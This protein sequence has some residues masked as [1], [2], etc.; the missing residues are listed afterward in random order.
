[1]DKAVDVILGKVITIT[2]NTDMDSTTVNDQ[3]FTLKQGTVLVQGKVA[4]TAST[5][6]FTFTPTVPLLPFTIYTGTV[7]TG[8]KDTFHS[9]IAEEYTWS[10]TTI[11]VV[12]LTA[13][14]AIGGTTLGAGA[15]AQG[16][17]VA[18]EATPN[19]GYV[20][21]NWTEEGNIV[22]T[23][24]AYSSA[25]AGNKTLVA[26]FAVLAA[27]QF[28]VVLS[29]NPIAGGANVGSGAYAAGTAV[30]VAATPNA[31][32]TFINWTEGGTVVS[33]SPSYQFNI[34]ASRSLR[35]NY[36]TVPA[37]Q[38]A[39]TLSSSPVSGGSTTGSGSY[40]AATSVT[41]NAAPNM[42]YTF[43]SWTE[44]GVIVS[45]SP[46]YTLVIN[47]N[48]TL[49]ANFTINTYTLILNAVNGTATASPAQATYNYGATVQ[50]TAKPNAGY[51]FS[52]WTGDAGGAVSPITVTMTANK[53]ITANFVP[54]AGAGPIDIDLGTAG[55]FATLT[56][57]GISTT[58]LTTVT[59]NIGVS[60]SAATSITGFGLIMDTDGTSSHTPIVIGK[61]YA[62]NYAAPTP[63]K[64][65]T[66]VS[67]MET[68]FSAGNALVTPAPVVGLYDGDLS[69]RTL[70]AGLYKWSTGVLITNQGL[71]LNGG[72]NDV[73]VFQIAQDLT[74]NNS[75]IITLTGGAQAKNIFWVV[76]GQAT[77]GSNSDV[78]GIILSKTLISLNT[79]A[80]VT[81]RL[82][83][84]TAV[85]LNAST[86]I[87]P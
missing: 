2:F 64:M 4:T 62:A 68:A 11:P 38:F 48:K 29:S 33:T 23:S 1:M 46:A 50:L 7:T 56:K 72:P 69:G 24:A 85:T 86:V 21:V 49:V 28:A 6:I 75:A 16:A 63:A 3:T 81:G 66:A 71:I 84:Q 40:N 52:T 35:A 87:Q 9:A 22:S 83:A 15:F 18:V 12:T 30:T 39:L 10:F 32:Y 37:A 45:A 14:P 73:W 58:G 42:G 65:T 31:G 19:T 57:A 59:G 76:S 8:A 5:K 43:T 44:N 34:T 79:G 17:T 61:V 51:A 55:D 27:G 54:S 36:S 82:L 41:I 25:M 80:K 26:N 70:A 20:F 60:P 53:N 13:A 74:I 78:S 47:A 67:D 77:L